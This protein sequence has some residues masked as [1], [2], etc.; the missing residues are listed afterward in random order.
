MYYADLAGIL[1][2]GTPRDPK[3]HTLLGW[4]MDHDHDCQRALRCSLIV[5]KDTG[6]PG[7][8]Y[9]SHARGLGLQIP[10]G[11]EAEFHRQQLRL[12]GLTV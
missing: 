11:D 6:R 2:Y 7:D 5:R 3:M 1:G 12:L 8:E 10:T 4:S 9:M